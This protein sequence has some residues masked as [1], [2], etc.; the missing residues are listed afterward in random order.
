[1]R[2]VALLLLLVLASCSQRAGSSAHQRDAEAAV[3]LAPGQALIVR[4]DYSA[5]PGHVIHVRPGN[6][7]HAPLGA[8]GTQGVLVV[9]EARGVTIDLGGQELRG[10][11]PGTHL[12]RLTGFGIVLEDCHDVVVRGGRVGGYKVGLL[13]VR[14]VGLVL[15]DL[16]FEGWYGQRLRSTTAAEDQ[17]DWL[18]PHANDE[19]E[20]L[21]NYGGAI[22]LEDC[23]DATIRRA[24]GRQGQN[25]I[26]LTRCQGTRVYDC[27]FSFL[28]G[29]G[30]ALYRTNGALV[31]RNRFDY[32]VRGYSHGVYWRGQDSSGILLF[33]RCSDNVFAENSATHG[34]DGVFL[35]AG[36]DAVE[37]RAFE[38]GETA[39]GGSDRNIWWG[40]DF[41]FAVANAIEATFSSDNWAIGNHLDGSHQHGVWGGYSRR[42]VVLGNSI[43]HTKG[44]GVSI[45]H[46]Q[47]CAI[48]ENAIEGNDMGIELWW[49]EDPSLVGG[50]FGARHD[51]SSRDHLVLGN[52]L[53]E[54]AQDLVLKLTTGVA[55]AQNEVGRGSRT[56]KVERSAVLVEPPA[57]PVDVAAFF[58]RQGDL[59]SG[60]V[61]DSTLR[62]FEGAEPEWL[63]RARQWTPPELPGTRRPF[64]RERGA[65]AGLDTIVMGEWGPWDFESG[66]P[67]PV[68]RT[69]GGMLAGVTWDA[70]WFRWAPERPDEPGSGSD[71]RLDVARWRA[72]AGNPLVRR[73]VGAWTN[74]WAGDDALRREVGNAHFGLVARA[75]FEVAEAGLHRLSVVS[76]DGVRVLVGGRV[77]LENWTWHAPTRD[78]ATLD[79]AAGG[80]EIVL[81][82]FQIDGAAAL[83]VE[84]ER[85][86]P[87]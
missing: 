13:A 53:A 9:R 2:P 64:A 7:T 14:C 35:F 29:W 87:R 16:E 11:P 69:P 67:R 42:M 23:R 79:L 61:Q 38:R 83:T 8:D 74:P 71:P 62:A 21:T 22:A 70:L 86:A 73:A 19:R 36:R 77:A 58:Q 27:D 59:P 45:E 33:E 25:G 24:R 32:C 52:R 54:N 17:G 63:Q 48:V 65:P 81:E 84:L 6:W 85:L 12:D 37:G 15:E 39:V 10:A 51:T 57:K 78:E 40:N 72:L 49:D 75:R 41:S 34:G 50:P 46:G 18:W 82:Y 26:L 31:A 80:H 44:G 55:F 60:L 20:W 5:I 47:E 76:D 30:L 43:R 68:P 56:L 66:A 3:E 1:M 28:S 4:G